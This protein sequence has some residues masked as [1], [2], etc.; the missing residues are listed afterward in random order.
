VQRR[1]A[2]AQWLA[3]CVFVQSINALFGDRQ[4]IIAST[5]TQEGVL[6]RSHPAG[7]SML[8]GVRSLKTQRCLSSSQ[9]GRRSEDVFMVNACMLKERVCRGVM[10]WSVNRLQPAAG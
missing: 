1:E 4:L 9:S 6:T 10:L 5:E 7:I 8:L 2:E 3:G